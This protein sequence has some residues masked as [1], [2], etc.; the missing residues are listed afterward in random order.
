MSA[1]SYQTNSEKWK[2]DIH[3]RRTGEQRL[4]KTETNPIEFQRPEF[5]EAFQTLN[6]QVTLSLDKIDFYSG[7]EN[8]FNYKQP[9]PIISANDPFGPFFDT[10][11]VWGPIRGREFYIGFR[12]TPEQKG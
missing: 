4:P 1:V 12:Y 9:N 5:S 8:I 7:C 3:Y 6:F 11:S 2:F 10:S